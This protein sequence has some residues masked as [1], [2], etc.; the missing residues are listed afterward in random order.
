MAQ[1]GR[2]KGAR[3]KKTLAREKAIAEYNGVDPREY[4]A[5]MLAGTVEFDEVK[6]MAANALMPYTYAKLTS[7]KID[8]DVNAN[9]N[10]V[11]L[12]KSGGRG[13]D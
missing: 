7:A 9:I 10:V 12:D 2:P 3:N 8:A 5:G 4:L 11:E 13:K 1:R 6:Y